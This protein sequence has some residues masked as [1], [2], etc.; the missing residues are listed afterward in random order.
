MQQGERL[1]QA[2]R[3]R[4]AQAAPAAAVEGV[5]FPAGIAGEKLPHTLQFIV[6]GNAAGGADDMAKSALRRV[7]DDRAASAELEIR[8]VALCQPVGGGVLL[9]L[10]R[11]V[12]VST[13][14]L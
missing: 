8:A 2:T 11:G 5:G 10:L 9:C 3:R 6:V 14:S 7:N 13:P 1:I 12:E 4:L